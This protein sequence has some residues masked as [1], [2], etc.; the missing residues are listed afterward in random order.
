MTD[1]ATF[2][3]QLGALRATVTM[4]REL[5]GALVAYLERWPSA[6]ISWRR[7]ALAD[8][9]D[10]L[11]REGEKVTRQAEVEPA[12]SAE[13]EERQNRRR[14]DPADL[15]LAARFVHPDGSIGMPIEDFLAWR[16]QRRREMAALPP[17]AE[18]LARAPSVT[19]VRVHE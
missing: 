17:L 11:N 12:R 15:D 7:G 14:Y 4:A 3:E 1:E 19:E 5:D 18:Q 6:R 13:R 16:E 2:S 10:A 8:I 9:L